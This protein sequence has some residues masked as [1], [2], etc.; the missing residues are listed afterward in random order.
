VHL[1]FVPF[2]EAAVGTPIAFFILLIIFFL[3]PLMRPR[4]RAAF[5]CLTA[6]VS[7]SLQSAGNEGARFS[8]N[9]QLD[10]AS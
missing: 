7:L 9:L 8:D 3:K 6:K 5:Q 2:F 1:I 4:W 10:P